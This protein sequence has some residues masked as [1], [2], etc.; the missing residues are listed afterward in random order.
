[1]RYA[2]TAPGARGS[3]VAFLSELTISFVLITTILVTSNRK[4]AEARYTPYFVGFLYAGFIPFES[5]LSGMSMNPARSFAPAVHAGYWHAL[6]IY[7]SA[8]TL[9][10]LAGAE[11]FLRARDGL[12][13]FSAKLHHNRKRCIFC[14]EATRFAHSIAIILALGRR[15]KPGVI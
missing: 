4:N 15:T 12:R 11:V 5:P 13:P 2:V 14:H 10:M 7:F 6:W 3:G 8:P 1:V 9:G